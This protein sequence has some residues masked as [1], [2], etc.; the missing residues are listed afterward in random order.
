MRK[1]APKPVGHEDLGHQIALDPTCKQANAMARAA[2][3]SRFAYNWALHEWERQYRAGGK[4][5]ADKL[6]KQFNSIRGQEFP[7]TY[8]SPRDATSQGII[9]LG[10][11]FS[12]FFGSC[13]GR[14]K[15]PKMGYPTP[16]RRGLDDAFYLAN[17][18]FRTEGNLIHIPLMGW[19]KM[20]EPLRLQG[21]V[22]CARVFRQ[23]GCWYV[24]IQVQGEFRQPTVHERAIVGVDL[25][26]KVA[27]MPSQGEPMQAPAPLRTG[28]KQLRRANRR[29]HRRQK[30]S[31]NRFKARMRVAQLH[32]RIGNIR[33]DWAHKTTTKL[34]RE[35]QAVVIE[36]LNV[37][38]M[39]KNERLARSISDVGFGMIRNL[40]TYKG[41]LYGCAVIVADRWFPS[42]KRC[43][44]CGNV[45]DELLLSERTYTCDQCG[46]I[47]DRDRNAALNLEKYPG[48]LGNWGRKTPTPVKTE[49][50]RGKRKQ[51]RQARSSKQELTRDHL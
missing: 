30:G 4:P 31:A 25:G 26:L 24:S 32:Q 23:A 19:V 29:L 20:R 11:A 28:L 15:G 37:K 44:R 46:L 17:D 40:L 2:G 16:R 10:S 3:C 1:R 47:E 45:K 38:G 7:W 36:D 8:E 5:S 27:V 13:S 35:N 48:L 12:A 43:S 41:R 22:L 21:K 33:R 14:R 9:D 39:L 51:P 42:S 49:P 18:K 34:T 50:L 6:K